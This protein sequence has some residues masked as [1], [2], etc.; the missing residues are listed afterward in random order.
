MRIPLRLV[1]LA[2][3]L[4][5]IAVFIQVGEAIGVAATLALTVLGMLA[6]IVLLRRQGMVTLSRLQVDLAAGRPPARPL[7]EGAAA[8][9]GALLLILPGF[10]SDVVGLLLFVPA[11]RNA[12]WSRIAGRIDVRTARQGAATPRHVSVIELDR[13]EYGAAPRPDSPWRRGEGGQS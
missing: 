3:V 4:A 10:I 12:I 9:I 1:F 6:G 8:T 11:V 2:L 5:E 13:S 7:A